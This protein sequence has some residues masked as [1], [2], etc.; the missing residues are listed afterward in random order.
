M[1]APGPLISRF[2]PARWFAGNAEA[3]CE[4]LSD[5]IRELCMAENINWVLEREG[6][7]SASRLPLP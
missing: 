5:N 4:D 1:G 2:S 3:G 7:R 6:P